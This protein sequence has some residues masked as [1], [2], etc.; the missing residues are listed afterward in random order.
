MKSARLDKVRAAS[1]AR[2]LVACL[3][4]WAVA[5]CDGRRDTR[6]FLNMPDMHFSPAVKAQEPNPF[7]A[8]GEMFRPVP[9]TVPVHWQPYT[10]T[11]AQADELASA[12]ENPLPA[13]ADVLTIGRKY[14]GIFCISCHGA[15]GN[16]LGSVVLANAGMPMP[17]SLT[18]EKLR[19]EWTDGRIFHVITRGQGQMP[20]YSRIDA[21]NRWAIVHYLRAL[22]RAAN[23]SEDEL[24]MVGSFTAERSALIR[25]SN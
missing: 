16:G 11:D 24:E 18:S 8:T 25:P 2:L 21:E 12:L 9:G 3:A 14:Y 20:G 15:T 17:P 22:Q 19:D 13:T 5:A 4:A 6:E 23:P 7:S 10:I 1:G